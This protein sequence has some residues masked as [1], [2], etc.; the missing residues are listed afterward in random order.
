MYFAAMPLRRGAGL[1]WLQHFRVRACRWNSSPSHSC[2]ASARALEGP[3]AS[4]AGN[5]ACR[6]C[7]SRSTI[8]RGQAVQP[9][10]TS[11]K[12]CE[13]RAALA[14]R[15]RGRVPHQR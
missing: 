3:V 15:L 9:F 2:C 5:T 1:K 4:L 12:P 11:L 14:C 6:T 13:S 8:G 7:S 10:T